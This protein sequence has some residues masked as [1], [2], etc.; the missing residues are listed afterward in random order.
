[1]IANVFF[2]EEADHV[3]NRDLNISRFFK[4]KYHGDRMCD[5]PKMNRR[6]IQGQR[7]QL[8][9]PVCLPAI[10]MLFHFQNR[11]KLSGKPQVSICS[12]PT[13]KYFCTGN[14]LLHQLIFGW[15]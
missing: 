15:K 8:I 1:M 7:Q 2:M 3:I 5:F 6:Y 12:L 14:F 13:D 11:R 4:T 9:F 10:E